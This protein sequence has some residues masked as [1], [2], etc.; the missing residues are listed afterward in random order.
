MEPRHARSLG[1]DGAA[2]RVGHGRQRGAPHPSECSGFSRCGERDLPVL[3]RP[4]D[5][6]AV[7]QSVA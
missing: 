4:N 5:A 7:L 1:R 2:R 3:R 6:E